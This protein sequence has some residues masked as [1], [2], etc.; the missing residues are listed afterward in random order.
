MRSYRCTSTPLT[1]QLR[2]ILSL[3]DF[4]LTARSICRGRFSATSPAARGKRALHAAAAAY[5]HW[6]L[7]PRVLVDVSVRSQQA[8]LFGDNYA[9]PFGS[10]R[11]AQRADCLR[12]RYRAGSSGRSREHPNDRQ[13]TALTRLE[14]VRV[15]APRSTWF[16]RIARRC[17]EN[18]RDGAAGAVRRLPHAGADRRCRD[19][20]QPREQHSRRFHYALRPS[21]RLAW[22]GVV[23]PRWTMERCFARC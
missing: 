10:R 12:R 11:W 20:S 19:A 15:A 14:D 7:V 8:E 5:R 21:V 2:N 4:E 23:R 16:Q 3:A 6:S 1:M 9:S 17:G 18:R 22:D 13:L